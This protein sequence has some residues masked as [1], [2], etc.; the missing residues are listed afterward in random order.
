MSV[1]LVLSLLPLFIFQLL[2]QNSTNFASRTGFPEV[3]IPIAIV[4]GILL[5]SGLFIF[6]WSA[7]RTT[8]WVG[9][10][11]SAA[12]LFWCILIFQTLFN[13][14]G[15]SFKPHYIASVFAS[16]DLFRSVIASVFPLFGAPLFDN[17]ATLNIQLL[18]GSSVLGFITLVMIAIPVLFYLNGPK[19]R[20]R[21]KYANG[22]C[23]CF[24][25]DISCYRYINQ[26]KRTDSCRECEVFII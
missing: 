11:F 16:N 21:S 8:H 2:E 6:G 12:I 10:L 4:G 22:R 14:M 18:G 13:F 17:L 5:T 7:N 23:H 15:A 3:F 9:P 24:P 20:A 1:L 19:L 25:I 26:I